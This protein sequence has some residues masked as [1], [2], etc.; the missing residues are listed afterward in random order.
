MLVSSL[1]HHFV[2]A[3]GDADDVATLEYDFGDGGHSY[4]A[5]VQHT[6]TEPGRIFN[7]FV[8]LVDRRGQTV[9][10]VSTL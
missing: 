3:T 10:Q 2:Y 9:V 6:Y 4:Q 1:T 5:Q 7:G 8:S